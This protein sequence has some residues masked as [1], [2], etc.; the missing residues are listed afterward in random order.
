MYRCLTIIIY[1]D[2]K[3]QIFFILTTHKKSPTAQM[4]MKNSFDPK[5]DLNVWIKREKHRTCLEFLLRQM[6]AE[7]Q[8]PANVWTSEKC[9]IHWNIADWCGL[10]GKT[11]MERLKN[12]FL[13]SVKQKTLLNQVVIL[14]SVILNLFYHTAQ[15]RNGSFFSRQFEGNLVLF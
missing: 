11:R 5:I 14:K 6:Q 3:C 2:V 9:K 4:G 10:R 8:P 12:R 15:Y 7:K 1:A 13:K